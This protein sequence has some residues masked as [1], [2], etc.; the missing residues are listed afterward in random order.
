MFLA[1]SN[2]PMA[3]TRQPDPLKKTRQEALQAFCARK[4]WKTDGGDWNLQ[5]IHEFFKKPRNKMS[6]LLHGRGS[7]GPHI[8][9]DLEEASNRELLP[10]ELD[11]AE[12]VQAIGAKWPFSAELGKRVAGLSAED[13]RYAENALRAHLKMD[14]LPGSELGGALEEAA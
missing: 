9:R 12:H 3:K 6:D 11:G 2:V 14:Q 8:A 5:K 10:F 1:C 7:F 4:G 13:R